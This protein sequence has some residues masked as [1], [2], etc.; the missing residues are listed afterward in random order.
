MLV[1]DAALLG[2]LFLATIFSQA[3]VVGLFLLW[4]ITLAILVPL[5]IPALKQKYII[6]PLFK[7]TK[8]MMP[9][10]SETEE[11]AIQAGTVNWDGEIFSGNPDW[12]AMYELSSATLTKEEQDFID[13]PTTEL[14]R[15]AKPWDYILR[16]EDSPPELVEFIKDNGFMSFI[17]DKKYGGKEFSALGQSEVQIKFGSRCHLVTSYV[18][19]PNS[20]GPAELLEKYGTQ[21]QKN[22]Y[23]PR[24]A[25]GKEIPCF[26]LTAPSAGSDAGSIPDNG[27]ICKEKYKDKE[28]VG[29]KLNFKKRYITLSPVATLI[30]L[31]FKLYDPDNLIGDV[32][33]YGITCALIPADTKGVTIGR[34]HMPLRQA[35]PNGPIVGE[36]V[37]IPLDSIIGGV[38]MAGK[39]W[40]MLVECLAVGRVISLPTISAAN[41]KTAAYA[42][43]LY[44]R[45]RKQFG[46]PIG[47]FEGIQESLADIA[48]FTFIIDSLRL[49]TLAAVGRGEKPAVPSAISKYHCT[50][51]GRKVGERAM[52][53][54]G[55][56]GIMM[57][58]K[59]YLAFAYMGI[60]IAITV[61]GANILTRN[62]I[63]FGQGVTRCHP[64]LL[65]EMMALRDDD[66]DKFGV[67]VMA[68]ISHLF[69]NLTRSFV[70]GLTDGRLVRA[71]SKAKNMKRTIQKL[72]R[73]SAV[74]AF[75]TDV[76]ILA[77]GGKLKRKESLSARLGDILSMIYI[78]SAVLKRYEELGST[79]KMATVTQWSC[80]YLL[81]QA[82]EALH[83]LLHN[84]PIP[85]LGRVMKF[86]TLPFGRRYHLPD[87]KL[88][89]TLAKQLM[90][91]EELRG[92]LTKGIYLED[93]EDNNLAIL[94][95]TVEKM[96]ATT[97]LEARVIKARKEGKINGHYFDQSIKD[98][99]KE[100]IINKEEE[101][102][103]MDA[104]NAMMGV[105]SVD[106]FDRDEII[107]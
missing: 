23:L 9:K 48:G 81:Y 61:E 2:F 21:E 11:Q 76:T 6:D 7:K 51:L 31:A 86:I 99:A 58:P 90:N 103:L 1:W 50:E 74:L 66:V 60:P 19:V 83:N 40:Q 27:I 97:G 75:V 95:K 32:K 26:A 73:Y 36:D 94:R 44:A 101:R 52:D 15:L 92:V 62:M 68:H 13:G 82:Q 87:D 33:D 91:S 69:S 98:A 39:G 78:C 93:R 10:L 47:A 46:L 37:F 49:F 14:C 67:S 8:K 71:P 88:R 57:G 45:V 107:Q 80:D 18:G 34:R 28:I 20:L 4:A 59:N 105:I 25:T 41:A 35:F 100:K 24:L 79:K 30:G 3:S 12:H 17:I 85:W 70:L 106:D 102:A 63:I 5:N 22:Y 16:N 55:G 84:Y 89:S 42:T 65:D 38:E 53:I 43:G 56:K 64:F 72:T 104:F 54:H 77:L 29:I 96:D